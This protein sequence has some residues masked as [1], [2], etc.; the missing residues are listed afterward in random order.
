MDSL[1]AGPMRDQ[2]HE[3]GTRLIASTGDYVKAAS[4]ASGIQDASRRRSAMELL[5]VM[6]SERDPSGASQWL[7]ELSQED[8]AM[9]VK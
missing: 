8:R 3:R 5:K 7:G 9:L 2:I 1:E 4:Y 6:W